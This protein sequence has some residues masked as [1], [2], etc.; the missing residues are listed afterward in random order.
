MAQIVINFLLLRNAFG[1]E[2]DIGFEGSVNMHDLF[3]IYGM[4]A[5]IIWLI[6]GLMYLH[7]YKKRKILKLDRDELE[8]TTH[9]IL[10]NFIVCFVALFSVLLAYFKIDAWPG[11]VY[12]LISPLI[13][14]GF[15]IKEKYYKIET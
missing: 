6:L 15:F 8:V 5:F 10:A 14:L 2:F 3:I 4:G 7:A 12:F 11:M 1:I 13:F 9:T